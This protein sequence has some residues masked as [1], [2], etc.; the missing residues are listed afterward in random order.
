MDVIDRGVG[1]RGGARGAAGVDDRGA[2]LGDAWDELVGDPGLVADRSQ[3]DSPPTSALTR[4]GYWVGEWLP[5]IVIFV[6]SVTATP[7]LL[8]SWEIARLWSRRIIAVKRSRGTSGAFD[9]AIRAFVLAGLP[10]TST[11]MSSA[12]PALIA[13]P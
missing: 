3:A 7:S 13:S 11:L 1:G 2:A 9:I 8:A 12:A 4:S 6:I 10:T 5:Q